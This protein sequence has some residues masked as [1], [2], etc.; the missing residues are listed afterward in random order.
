MIA[1]MA[2]IALLM[3]FFIAVMAT[4]WILYESRLTRRFLCNAGAWNGHSTVKE[5]AWVS[6]RFPRKTICALPI[7]RLSRV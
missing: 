2:G 3:S 4:Y 5:F 6:A 1:T 7:W